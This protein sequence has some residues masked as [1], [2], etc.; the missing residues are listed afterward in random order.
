MEIFLF[1]LSKYVYILVT[2]ASQ[3]KPQ[4]TGMLFLLLV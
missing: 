3:N 4:F 1:L 2:F